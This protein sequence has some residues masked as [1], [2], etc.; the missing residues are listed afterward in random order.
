MLLFCFGLYSHLKLN[1]NKL[2]TFRLQQLCGEMYQK[3][4]LDCFRT[5]VN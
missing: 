2:S 3:L 1:A 4:R 5:C